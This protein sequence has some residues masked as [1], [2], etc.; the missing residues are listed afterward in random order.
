M[1]P[2]AMVM[3]HE[4]REQ[5]AQVGLTEHDDPIEAFLFDRPYEPLRMCI[6]I[7]R[8]KR[9]LHDP[10]ADIGQGLAERRAPLGA[11]SPREVER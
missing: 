2:L 8:L 6:A 9:R 5:S 3:R 10:D 7:R 4:R 1:I 11:S